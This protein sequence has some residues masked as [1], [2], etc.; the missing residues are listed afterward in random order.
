MEK[1]IIQKLK[2]IVKNENTTVS[3]DFEADKKDLKFYN[4][5]FIWGYSS[6][7]TNLIFNDSPFSYLQVENMREATNCYV[8]IA[9]HLK[10]VTKKRAL[11]IVTGLYSRNR[12]A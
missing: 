6:R 10:K 3:Q 1:H 9:G 4:G 5:N 8:C 12:C 11:A 7:G 2:M